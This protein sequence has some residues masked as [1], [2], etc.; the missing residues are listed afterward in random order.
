M[1]CIFEIRI[2]ILNFQAMI[3]KLVSLVLILLKNL[4]F[5]SCQFSIYLWYLNTMY[6]HIHAHNTIVILRCLFPTYKTGTNFQCNLYFILFFHFKLNI[7][8]CWNADHKKKI[9]MLTFRQMIANDILTFSHSKIQPIKCNTWVTL[10]TVWM[11][12]QLEQYCAILRTCVLERGIGTGNK[13]QTQELS[14]KLSS[15]HMRAD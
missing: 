2:L 6:S 8:W 5:Y 13:K 11:T 14:V 10:M 4:C 7:Y 1:L 15:Y 3:Q 12:S 9:E